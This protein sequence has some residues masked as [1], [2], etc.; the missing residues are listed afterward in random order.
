MSFTTSSLREVLTP[1]H[2]NLINLDDNQIV[3]LSFQGLFHKT[4]T[5]I[6]SKPQLKLLFSLVPPKFLK[7]NPELKLNS[8]PAALHSSKTSE[9][10]FKTHY[11]SFQLLHS[12]PQP[13]H[14]CTSSLP[15]SPSQACFIDSFVIFYF[16]AS[17][18]WILSF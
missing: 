4:P 12:S 10:R 17:S 8:L 11:T 1:Q 14:I 6:P 16:H 18:F 7:N 2:Q 9:N 13:A 5:L 15:S 3:A